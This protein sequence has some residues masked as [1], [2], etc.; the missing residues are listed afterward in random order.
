MKVFV[1]FGYNERDRWIEEQVFPVLQ[2][3]GFTVV[4]GEDMHGEILQQGVKTRI[5]QSDAAVGFLTLREGQG[6]AD[7]NSHIWVRDELVHASAKDKPIVPVVEQG[8]RVPTGLLGDRQYIPL[9]Q[10]DR[11][12]CVAELVR[13]LGHRNIRRLKLE[14]DDDVL[15]RNLHTWQR[16]NDFV[17]RYRSK[18]KDD[19]VSDAGTGRLEKLEQAFYLNV[20]NVPRR[21]LVEV[22]GV[23]N[24]QTQFSSGWVSAD[25]VS[26]KVN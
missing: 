4:S 5:D 11:L 2:C 16:N 20:A 22:E 8:V 18:D 17:I 19:N 6:E 13:A 25:A 26:V 12:A 23:L 15:R 3:M 7:F 21:A 1:G 9:R 14:T 24:G 10:E